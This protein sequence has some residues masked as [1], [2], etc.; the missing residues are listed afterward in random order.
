M[1]WRT[2]QSPPLPN[3][4]AVA[5]G[6][7]EDRIQKATVPS[8]GGVKAELVGGDAAGAVELNGGVAGTV[9]GPGG[10]AERGVVGL[11]DVSAAVGAGA[12]GEFPDSR[13]VPE[14]SESRHS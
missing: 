1:S 11:S 14:K 9:G 12:F 4:R 10:A 8:S 2:S 13:R 7:P 6:L 3:R 5:A